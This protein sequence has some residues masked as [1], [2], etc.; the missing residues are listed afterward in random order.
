M[1]S[2]KIVDLGGGTAGFKPDIPGSQAGDPLVVDR[3]EGVTWNNRTDQP[4]WP[5]PIDADGK[6]LS[7]VDAFARRLYLCDRIPDGLV[8]APICN[9]D[10]EF[11]PQPPPQPA[12]PNV[13]APAIDYVCRLH[14]HERGRIVVRNP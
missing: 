6:L 1:A 3:G 10:P 14:R 8:S 2:I 12:P 13:Q 9:I 7:D 4:H 5:W 11:S